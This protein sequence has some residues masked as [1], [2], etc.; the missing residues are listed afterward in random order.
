MS[1]ENQKRLYRKAQDVRKTE[2]EQTESEAPRESARRAF[3]RKPYQA[4]KLIKE[5]G[6]QIEKGGD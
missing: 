4:G 5:R 1:K 3:Q 2:L 6:Q